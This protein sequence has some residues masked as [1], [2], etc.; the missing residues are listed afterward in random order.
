MTTALQQQVFALDARYNAHRAPQSLNFRT[1]YIR[2]RSQLLRDTKRSADDWKQ[3]IKL[4]SALLQQRY[5]TT[6]VDSSSS[7]SSLNINKSV[8]N[9]R[10]IFSTTGCVVPTKEA[11][12]SRAMVGGTTMAENYAFVGVEHIFDQHTKAVTMVK[13]ANNDRTRLCCSSLD[14]NLSVCDLANNSPIVSAV[15]KGHIKAV[16][17]FDWSIN[18]DLIVSASLDGS[19]RVWKV[20]DFKCLS[21]IKE[22]NDV[23]ILCCVFQ[24]I[25]NNLILAGNNKGELRIANISTGRYLK[26]VCRIGGNILSI[27]FD[28][29]GKFLWAGNDRGEI[30]S[31]FC[32]LNEALCKMKKFSLASHCSITS[33]S[34][35]AWISREARDPLLLVNATDNSMYLLSITDCEGSLQ[36]KRKFQ[37]RH[38]KHIVRST[39]CP[40]MSF[41]QGACVVTGSED[42][43]IYF[44]DI[45][46]M[47]NRSVVNTLQGHSSSVLSISFNYDES[48]LA[49]SDLQGL[50]IIWKKGNMSQ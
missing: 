42:G 49:T 31:V 12:A 37:N 22:N 23:Q 46:K 28:T 2:R 20:A 19:I 24:P 1:L 32:E 18:N 47:G 13:F 7:I 26:Y 25:N 40:I 41:R 4:R 6:K 16:T 11:E 36:L 8:I 9:E 21:I 33:L 14:G 35:R 10:T 29:N 15:L 27:A 50:V 3:Y 34:Y 5:G 30:V 48:F 38:Q 44:V 43:S 17:G 45:E 39:F